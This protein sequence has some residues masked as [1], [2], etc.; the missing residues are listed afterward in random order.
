M[1]EVPPAVAITRSLLLSTASIAESR[2]STC[3]SARNAPE[4]STQRSP[5]AAPHR[6]QGTD[7]S[8][9]GVMSIILIEALLLSMRRGC[10]GPSLKTVRNETLRVLCRESKRVRVPGLEL[11][12][13]EVAPVMFGERSALATSYWSEGNSAKRRKLSRKRQV[14]TMPLYLNLCPVKFSVC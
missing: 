13:V 7:D 3:G 9:S 11:R 10:D 12:G 2:R 4:C 6:G 5:V 8:C 1:S 14:C